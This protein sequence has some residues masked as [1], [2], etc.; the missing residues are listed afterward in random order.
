MDSES[1]VFTRRDFL[2][3][4]AIGAAVLAAGP[5]FQ[6]GA[7]EDAMGSPMP[8]MYVCGICGHVEFGMAPES[9]PV[10]HAPKEKFTMNNMIFSESA[11][12]FN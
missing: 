9:C 4:A 1:S 6:V 3:T 2:H 8:K 5:L 12:K 10:C 7:K 11:E